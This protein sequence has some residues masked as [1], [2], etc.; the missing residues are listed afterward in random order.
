MNLLSTRNYELFTVRVSKVRNTTMLEYR[1]QDMDRLIDEYI[2]QSNIYS[3]K[4]SFFAPLLIEPISHYISHEQTDDIFYLKNL[5]KNPKYYLLKLLFKRV[6]CL[7][8]YAVP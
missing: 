7:V 5:K 6:I 8:I 4:E 1:D 3:P 2:E